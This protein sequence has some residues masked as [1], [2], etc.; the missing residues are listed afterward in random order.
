MSS[1]R[2]PRGRVSADPSVVAAFV[3]VLIA[4]GC[5]SGPSEVVGPA[6]TASPVAEASGQVFFAEPPGVDAP[7]LTHP[8]LIRSKPPRVQVWTDD[9]R[10]VR[11]QGV[12]LE[13]SHIHDLVIPAGEAVTFHWSARSGS[14]G[15]DIV[16]YRWALDILDI[17][18]E[19]PRL[20]DSDLAHWSV[21][22]PTGTSATVGPFDAGTGAH[23]FY[24]EARDE[25]GFISLVTI[26][27]I[28][29][30]GDG[31]VPTGR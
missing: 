7:P 31:L 1:L 25:R 26:R 17:T 11:D 22:T 9:W 23:H 2:H 18:D 13:P 3:V 4:P 19:T 29:D 21:W 5:S 8:P 30:A 28:T 24:V 15:W 16:G 10:G 12:S 27:V 6:R 20:D 14:G